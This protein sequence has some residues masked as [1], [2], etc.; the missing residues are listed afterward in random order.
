MIKER[1]K[2]E[3]TLLREYLHSEDTL[4]FIELINN[5]L[6]SNNDFLDEPINKDYIELLKLTKL[7]YKNN[8][9]SNLMINYTYNALVSKIASILNKVTPKDDIISKYAL[10][11]KLINL[12]N[13][14]YTNEEYMDYYNEYGLDTVFGNSCCRHRAS[15]IYDVLSKFTDVKRITIGENENGKGNHTIVAFYD[16]EYNKYLFFDPVNVYLY[17]PINNDAIEDYIGKHR[18]IKAN[19][20]I[21]YFDDFYDVNKFLTF[22]RNIS[23]SHLTNDEYIDILSKV[24]IAYNILPLYYSTELSVLK[25]EFASCKEKA[26]KLINI[27]E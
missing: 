17:N 14:K 5:V 19:Y 7:Y 24:R 21:T 2:K 4:L 26:K 25:E 6:L 18:Y 3:E 11:M 13:K 16:T 15:L 1:R 12:N 22:Y 9:K 10:L 23:S 27:K 8:R 20:G